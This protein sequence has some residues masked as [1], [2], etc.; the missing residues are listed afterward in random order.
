MASLTCI[1]SCDSR[2]EK[3]FS[4]NKPTSLLL[5]SS[6]CW[7][8]K[9]CQYWHFFP[10]PE[11][12]ICMPL[13]SALFFNYTNFIP[14]IFSHFCIPSHYWSVTAATWFPI[15]RSIWLVLKILNDCGYLH[16]VCVVAVAMWGCRCVFVTYMN[17]GNCK[18]IVRI[19]L[20]ILLNTTC[21]NY[22][23]Q[24]VCSALSK[25]ASKHSEIGT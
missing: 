9:L 1:M 22:E 5:L 18:E 8:C 17:Q 11:K 15:W 13:F 14:N 25:Q 19:Y 21:Y 16:H 3:N 10:S 12:I 23:I 2:L 24:V 6:K 7:K 4:N 20:F